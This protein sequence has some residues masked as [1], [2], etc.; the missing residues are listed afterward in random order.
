MAK[1]HNTVA[2]VVANLTANCKAD[3]RK[4]GFSAISLVIATI[5]LLTATFSWYS[6]AGGTADSGM[7]TVK[8]G[9][10]LVLNGGLGSSTLKIDENAMLSPASSVDGY[11]LYLPADGSF[12]VTADGSTE[13]KTE[14][15]VFR[16]A[17]AGDKNTNYIQVDF[18]LASETE[19]SSVCLGTDSYIK[20]TDSNGAEVDNSAI[21]IS[22][23]SGLATDPVV[24]NPTANARTV[25]A[26]SDISVFT[27]KHSTS[28]QQISTPM[29]T[30]EAQPIITLNKGET[31]RI[32]LIIWLEG[33][34]SACQGSISGKD[35]DI[36]LDL[37][38]VPVTS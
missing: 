22:A 24:L 13:M 21:R 6:I 37:I 1:F 3:K 31:T 8:A 32:S 36:S 34:D 30:G 5:V 28:R 11:N 25:N 33:T 9:N 35:L 18:T 2:E 14:N 26:V 19:T 4:L 29:K 23:I 16:R 27:G 38:S 15:M 12:P 10:G 17:N 20:I 7:M